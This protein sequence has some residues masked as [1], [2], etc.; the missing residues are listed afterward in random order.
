MSQPSD[1]LD[2][3]EALVAVKL[4]TVANARMPHKLM[5]DVS[6]DPS[7][8]LGSIDIST[9]QNLPPLPTSILQFPRES[10]A[11]YPAARTW[12]LLLVDRMLDCDNLTDEQWMQMC[13]VW[14]YGGKTR[15]T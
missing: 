12:A 14:Q 10:W 7:D 13:L 11:R 9:W 5:P 15:L 8:W 1:A 2:V 3:L 6:F 4:A